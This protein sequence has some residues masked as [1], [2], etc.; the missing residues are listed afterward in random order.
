M[1]TMKLT[2]A[3][4]AELLIG[5]RITNVVL[6]EKDCFGKPL[7]QGE[8]II[9]ELELDGLLTV[10]LSASPQIEMDDVFAEV[11]PVDGDTDAS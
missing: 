5:R 3:Q 9:R 8:I 2:S 10:S 4:F 1:S 6:A 7:H 11:S